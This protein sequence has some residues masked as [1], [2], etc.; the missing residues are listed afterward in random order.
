MVTQRRH[1]SRLY[2]LLYLSSPSSSA[3]VAVSVP[4]AACTCGLLVVCGYSSLTAECNRHVVLY[5]NWK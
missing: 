4:V 2:R 5:Y 3:A 1:Y